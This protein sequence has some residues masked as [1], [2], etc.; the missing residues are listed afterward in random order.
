[1]RV[2]ITGMSGYVGGVIARRVAQL[3]EVEG[4]RAWT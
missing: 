3:P 2:L 1:M 4:S